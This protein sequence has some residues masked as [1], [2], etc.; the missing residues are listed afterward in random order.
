MEKIDVAEPMVK[1]PVSLPNVHVAEPNA[2]CSGGDDERRTI[3]D[4]Y[5]RLLEDHKVAQILVCRENIGLVANFY[6]LDSILAGYGASR[7]QPPDF[8]IPVAELSID[9]VL[10]AVET[11]WRR[12]T[13]ES[14]L[15]WFARTT[16]EILRMWS[17]YPRVIGQ[18][19]RRLP[20]NRSTSFS[21]RGKTA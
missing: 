16:V 13:S 7:P 11:W 20:A 4:H 14:D 6:L 18:P 12:N 8:S 19:K 5:H 3:R 1:A 15:R 9:A 2:P 21:L 10:K 17:D